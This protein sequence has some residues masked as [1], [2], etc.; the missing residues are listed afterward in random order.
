MRR[1]Q[2][3]KADRDRAVAKALEEAQ[4]EWVQHEDGTVTWKERVYVPKDAKLREDIV[5]LHH[6]SPLAGHPGRYKTHEL[7]TRNY[8][9]PGIQK[10]IRK[11]VQGCEKCQRVKPIRQSPHNPLHPHS[12]PTEPWQEISVDLIGALPE[13][14]GYD[15]ICV[16]VDRFTKQIHVMPTSVTATSEGMAKLYKDHVFR[17]HGLPHKIIHDRGPQFDSRFMRD[18]YR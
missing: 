18:L 17:L 14:Q 2:R 16:F 15:A 9:W 3:A 1:I 4:P 8:W 6:D 13:S 12:I 11:Y 10:D 7:I 5:R